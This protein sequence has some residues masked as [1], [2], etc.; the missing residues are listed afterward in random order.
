MNMLPAYLPFIAIPFQE[1]YTDRMTPDRVG[2]VARDGTQ[3]HDGWTW[4]L[5]WTWLVYLPCPLSAVHSSGTPFTGPHLQYPHIFSFTCHSYRSCTSHD[6]PQAAHTTRQHTLHY[7]HSRCLPLSYPFL[8]ITISHLS[9]CEGGGGGGGHW[10]RAREED[11]MAVWAFRTHF[12]WHGR[13]L[14]RAD[15]Y[16]HGKPGR[17]FTVGAPLL[18]TFAS[19]SGMRQRLMDYGRSG[20]SRGSCHTRR[21][22]NAGRRH[23]WAANSST[24]KP[25]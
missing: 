17:G 6:L 4:D 12:G 9:W 20:R 23:S 21:K 15:S 11:A 10:D 25:P 22:D 8:C 24:N 5:P 7:H 2:Q 3:E 18:R 19:T 13:V 14:T 1:L 16:S